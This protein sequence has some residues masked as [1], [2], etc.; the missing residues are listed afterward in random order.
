[1]KMGKLFEKNID[2]AN[3]L[4]SHF[5]TIGNKLATKIENPTTRTTINAPEPPENSIY[6]FDSNEEELRKLITA[7]KNNK[8]P[9]LD[10]I[11][12][13]IIKV[14]AS[15]IIPVLVQVFNSCMRV[16]S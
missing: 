6:M 3:R 4:N 5:N 13:Y 2:I 9:G 1:M 14:S 7:L 15:Y 12:N 16:G 11:S 8:A 10:G